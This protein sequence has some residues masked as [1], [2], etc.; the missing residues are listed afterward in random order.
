[1]AKS[2]FVWAAAV[3]T[4]AL[5]VLARPPAHAADGP[6]SKILKKHGLKIVGSLAVVDEEA[7]IKSKLAEARRLS[8]QLSYSLMQQKATMSP[9]EH[10]TERSRRST[11][12]STSSGPR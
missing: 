2:C 4:V 10:A 11:I 8:K 3:L 9:G 7:E 1:M 12:R 5:R 6:A